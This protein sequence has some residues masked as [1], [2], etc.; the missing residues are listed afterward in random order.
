M[1]I[2]SIHV[3]ADKTINEVMSILENV[4]RGST[5]RLLV[6]REGAITDQQPLL[7]RP[8]VCQSTN[9][10][11][12]IKCSLYIIYYVCFIFFFISFRMWCS[13]QYHCKNTVELRKIIVFYLG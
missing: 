7:P 4:K 10:L 1:R 8:L 12:C 5:V 9:V 13:N 11:Y 3:T 2:N 6:R